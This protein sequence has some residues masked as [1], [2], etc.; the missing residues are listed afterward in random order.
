MLGSVTQCGAVWYSCVCCGAGIEV[1]DCEVCAD[2]EV[3][4][5]ADISL[6]LLQFWRASDPAQAAAQFQRGEPYARLALG[7][8]DFWV[9]RVHY[10][11]TTRLYEILRESSLP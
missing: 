9:S 1:T 2:Q 7:I 6:A 8:A 11:T 5:S 4:I 10:N 3:H